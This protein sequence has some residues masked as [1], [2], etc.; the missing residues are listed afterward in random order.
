[1]MLGIMLVLVLL[2]QALLVIMMLGMLIMLLQLISIIE[3][4]AFNDVDYSTGVDGEA[5]RPVPPCAGA[6]GNACCDAWAGT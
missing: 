6:P 4:L 3:F 2:S 5:A 1:M